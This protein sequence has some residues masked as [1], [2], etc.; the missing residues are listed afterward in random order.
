KQTF[1]SLS[2]LCFVLPTLVLITGFVSLLGLSGFIT[3][4]LGEDWS[5][6]GLQGILLAHV[7]MNLPFA[8]R[9]MHLQLQSIPDSSWILARQLK[10]NRWQRFRLIELPSLSANASLIF[11]F[12]T[13][14]CFNSFAVVLA[15]GGG[16][17]STTLEV[18][19]YQAL[20][21]DF[22]IPEALTLAWSQF[23]IAGVFFLLLYRSSSVP[24][25][26]KDSTQKLWQLSARLAA[27]FHDYQ[28][29]RSEM[30]ECWLNDKLY[31]TERQDPNLTILELAQKTLYCEIFANAGMRQKLSPEY[32]TLYEFARPILHRKPQKNTSHRHLHIFTPTRLSRFHRQLISSLGKSFKIHLYHLN[33]CSE[34][35][36]DVTTPSEDQ[37][38]R[39]FNNVQTSE[40]DGFYELDDSAI[41]NPL[42]KAWGKTGR[43]ALKVYS[44][45]EED[46]NYYSVQFEN[47]WLE[48]EDLDFDQSLLHRVQFDILR[49]STSDTKLD[50][51]KDLHSLQISGA[52]SMHRE[53]EAVYHSILFN[54]EENPSLQLSDIAV[55]TPDMIS[56]QSVFQQIFDADGPRYTRPL[57]YALIDSSASTESFYARAVNSLF[58]L[59]EEDFI[60]RDVFDFFRNPCF[61][62]ACKCSNDD[63]ENWLY[64]AESMGIFR[65]FKNLYQTAEL[66][67][68]YTWEQGLKRLRLASISF[69]DNPTVSCESIGRLSLILEKLYSYRELLTLKLSPEV[70]HQKLNTFFN[71][72][73]DIPQDFSLEAIVQFSLDSSLESLDILQKGDML[74][75]YQDIRQYIATEIDDIPAGKGNYLSGGLTIASLQPMRPIP[76]KLIYIL[77][78]DENSF[79]GTVENDSM[80]LCLRTRKI[81]DINRIESMN[82][83]FLETLVCCRE[84]LYLSYV[85]EN[86]RK[87]TE[88]LPSPVIRELINYCST[89]LISP[90][91]LDSTQQMPTCKLPLNSSEL[92]CFDNE[93]NL[94]YDIQRNSSFNNYLLALY[95]SHPK[96]LKQL[97]K[98]LKNSNDKNE[99]KWAQRAAQSFFPEDI[100]TNKPESETGPIEVDLK[101]LKTFLEN[102]LLATLKRQGIQ[103]ADQEDPAIISDE[104]FELAPLDKSKLFVPS[105]QSY[106][107]DEGSDELQTYVAENYHTSL[108]NSKVPIPLFTNFEKI[109]EISPEELQEIRSHLQELRPLNGPVIFGTSYTKRTAAL[110]LKALSITLNDGRRI[111]LNGCID[112]IWLNAQGQIAAAHIISSSDQSAPSRHTF[113]PFLL[114]LA[115]QSQT[116]I[117]VAES[118]KIY[119]IYRKRISMTECH[120]LENEEFSF[121]NSN[122]AENYLK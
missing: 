108:K 90:E 35:W 27:R 52:P 82:Y 101:E 85:A 72:F 42:L 103:T 69:D 67:L 77:G 24:W 92:Q 107:L 34:F 100:Q 60:R 81:G 23:A 61:Q 53:V 111:N 22:N 98:V 55:L 71:E 12:I 20:K 73:L 46:A 88:I 63:V 109:C 116:E 96:E 59:L 31:F 26:S 30:V 41:E 58:S 48:N 120:F 33:V 51:I 80:D 119:S 36:E 4:F 6:Y 78:L 66:Q 95:E 2:L 56:Y 122:D 54:M 28:M 57:P 47:Y 83:L 93:L 74:L 39:H 45:L 68:L 87:D 32:C 79:P 117:E 50:N 11:G 112:D 38:L 97:L 86:L 7:K 118:F 114:W 70:W 43:E 89:K 1:L 105:L 3:P 113:L 106:L 76:F 5:L 29:P 16:P 25:L 110:S 65:G 49:R 17:Q 102:P 14:L 8:V 99:R 21:Y 37:W 104:P 121:T 75:S 19:I 62:A 91:L 18:A 9:A 84:K 115:L 64:A 44:E 40:E 15:L 10:F 13:I 94:S